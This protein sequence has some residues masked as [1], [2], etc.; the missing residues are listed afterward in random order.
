MAGRVGASNVGHGSG[1]HQARLSQIFRRTRRGAARAVRQ[2][3]AQGA[4]TSYGREPVLS[5]RHLGVGWF[6][7]GFG[8]FWHV[9]F[10]LL[11]HA[12][13]WKRVDRQIAS[14]SVGQARPAAAQQKMEAL[15]RTFWSVWLAVN[16]LKRS[17]S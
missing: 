15:V 12:W 10:M 11:G 4:S 1:V 17:Q 8:W 3:V 14:R 6:C 13:S 7:G 9:F 5:C 16:E 2:S